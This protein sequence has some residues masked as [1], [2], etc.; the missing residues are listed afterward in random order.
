MGGPI[1][2]RWDCRPLVVLPARIEL[3]YRDHRTLC[4]RNRRRSQATPRRRAEAS[5]VEWS[6]TPSCQSLPV[7]RTRP[8]PSHR[9]AGRARGRPFPSTLALQRASFRGLCRSP[10]AL[11]VE[12]LFPGPRP[13]PSPR[14]RRPSQVSG[15]G[16]YFG[17][18]SPKVTAERPDLLLQLRLIHSLYAQVAQTRLFLAPGLRRPED[19]RPVLPPSQ[20][21]PN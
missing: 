5:S 16:P 13:H 20:P 12:Q 10:G 7:P 11:R 3:G 15:R 14:M 1:Q 17:N 21:A 6:S 8:A 4:G 18:G 2:E 9:R 19:A